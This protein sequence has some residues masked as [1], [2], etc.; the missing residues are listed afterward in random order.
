[1]GLNLPKPTYRLRT[2]GL[3]RGV[4]WY[5]MQFLRRAIGLHMHHVFVNASVS[6][7]IIPTEPGYE[8]REI[9]P[10]ELLPFINDDPILRRQITA[11]F[12][13]QS[14][15][16]NDRCVASFANDRLVGFDFSSTTKAP[17]TE[18][19]EVIVPDGFTYGYKGWTHSEHRRKKL[20]LR[21]IQLKSS[22]DYMS[23]YYIETHNYPSL[24]R[25]YRYPSERRQHMGYV[26]WITFRGRQYP[27]ASRLAKWIGFEF[28]RKGAETRR[29]YTER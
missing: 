19:L 27:F 4:Y 3:R 26:G 18:Q 6:K 8:H 21:R 17:V 11:D 15:V 16:Q 12:L 23:I 20:S 1:M 9:K 10:T 14:Q 7:S 5:V 28:V 25:P 13:S 2:L 22:V 29:L 24:L